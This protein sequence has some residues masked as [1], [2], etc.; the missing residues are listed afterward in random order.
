MKKFIGY[1]LIGLAGRACYEVGLRLNMWEYWVIVGGLI[2][3]SGLTHLE[4]K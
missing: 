1:F 4:D 3:G 2:V